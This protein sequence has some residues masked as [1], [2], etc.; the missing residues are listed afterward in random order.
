MFEAKLANAALLKKII[1]AI[2][3]LVT[4][5]PFDCSESAMCLQAMDSSHVALV[6]LKLEVRSLCF[7]YRKEGRRKIKENHRESLQ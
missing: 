6:S 4:D 2:K 5:A 7:F 3:D 1:E